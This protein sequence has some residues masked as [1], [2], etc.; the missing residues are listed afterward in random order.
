MNYDFIHP[1]SVRSF[2]R[3]RTGRCTSAVR[4]LSWNQT[5]KPLIPSLCLVLLVVYGLADKLR[6][7]VIGIFIPQYHYHYPV[8]LCFGQVL[9]SLLVLNL[10][11]FLGLVPLKRYSRS[12]G[13]KLLLPAICSSIQD[14]MVM[15]LKASSLYSG[16]FLLA[17]PLLPLVT[18]ALSFALKTASPPSVHLSVMTAILSGTSVVITAS[19]GFSHTEPLE[20]AYAPLALLLH[21]LSLTCLGKVSDAESRRP[22]EAQASAFDVY[23]TSLVNQGL[24]L[25]LLWLLHPDS[26][27]RVLSR[28]SW[29]SLLFNG[30]LHAILLLGT[31]LSFLIGMSALCVSPFAAAVLHSAKQVLEPFFLL[32]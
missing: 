18:V 8:V 27:R 12:L 31:L 21:G 29:N 14:V 19:R 11:H 25:G 26:L 10:L 3:S 32:L 15:W 13:E 23:Y 16:V 4:S 1:T 7:F 22:P 5:L 20:Y 28:G 9:V 17:L 24:V 30:Y 6:N 2:G